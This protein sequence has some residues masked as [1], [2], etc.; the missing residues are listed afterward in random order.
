MYDEAVHDFSQA[1]GIDATGFNVDQ[2]LKH[3]QAEAKKAKKKDYYKILGI[4]RDASEKEIKN[5][6]RKLALKW[7]P[8]KNN[9]SEEQRAH[10]ERQF[11]DV[12]EAYQILSDP[13]KRK[14]HDMGMS[15]DDISSGMGGF[16]GG[17]N[18]D[19]GG[20]PGGMQ[21]NMGGP[22]G[23]GGFDPSMIFQM[24]G[25]QMGGQGGGRGGGGFPGAFFSMPGFGRGQTGAGR[26]GSSQNPF[27]DFGPF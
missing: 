5:A 11:R 9:E 20:F 3:A 18:F 14:Q 16:P 6:Y 15:A 7:H 24:M 13:N 26:G 2:K 4:E 8:D 21:F 27:G 12:S 1:K 19:M 10:A 25:A 22:G 17:M 23:M